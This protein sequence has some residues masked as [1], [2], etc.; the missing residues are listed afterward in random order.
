MTQPTGVSP[1]CADARMLLPRRYDCAQVLPGALGGWGEAFTASGV[2]LTVD[3]DLVVG[4]PHDL[5]LALTTNAE[6]LL[7]M[8]APDRR[9]LARAGYSVRRHLVVPGLD[10]PR[11]LVPLVRPA[12]REAVSHHLA[13]ALGLRSIRNAAARSVAG[14]ALLARRRDAVVTVA[15]RLAPRPYGLAAAVAAGAPADGPYFLVLGHGDA[16]T[17]AVFIAARRDLSDQPVAIKLERLPGTAGS[18]FEGDERGLSLAAASRVAHVPRL[19]GSFIVAGAHGSVETAGRGEQAGRLFAKG[20]SPAAHRLLTRV[21]AWTESLAASTPDARGHGPGGWPA[22]TTHGDLGTWNIVTSGDEFTVLDWESADAH[23]LPLSDALYFLTD[24]LGLM[25]GAHTMQERFEYAVALHSGGAEHSGL[26]FNTMRDGAARLGLSDDVV[27]PLASA[28]WERHSR[29]RGTRLDRLA[30]HAAAAE[31]P[32]LG[33]LTDAWR[34]HPELGVT[35]KAFR[36]HID[37]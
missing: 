36:R 33:R 24:A 10:G 34:T 29:S 4:G 15:T 27:G 26:L 12:L 16:L 28:C 14:P 37:S 6:S 11:L 22:V 32:Y 13:P 18:S 23:G 5:R 19:L 21:V 1:R 9:A 35:W 7:L 31:E 17:R 8:G 20:R 3:A 2:A 25:A 30:D